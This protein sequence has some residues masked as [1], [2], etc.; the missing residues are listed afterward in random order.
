MASCCPGDNRKCVWDEQNLPWTVFPLIMLHCE[1]QIH[2]GFSGRRASL[3]VREGKQLIE[4]NTQQDRV[5]LQKNIK[6]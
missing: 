4:L 2:V 1:L 3:A 5:F 6:L